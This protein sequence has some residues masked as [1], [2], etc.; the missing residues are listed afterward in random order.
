MQPEVAASIIAAITA[1]VAVVI[2]PII[3]FK[4]QK[5]QVLAPMRQAWINSLRDTTSEF[6]ST[7]TISRWHVA[8]YEKEPD[9]IKAEKQATD[10]ARVELACKLKE[11]V[12]LLINP[13]EADHQELVRLLESAYLKYHDGEEINVLANAIRVQA[14]IIL[15]TEWNVVKR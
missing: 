13:K 11:K 10:M 3:T 2:G 14:Q 15:K 8:P 12:A 6:I 4:A 7:I 9:D 1:L 5:N